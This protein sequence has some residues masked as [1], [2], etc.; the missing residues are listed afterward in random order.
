[1]TIGITSDTEAEKWRVFI[2]ENGWSPQ[3]LD[4]EPS[5]PRAFEVRAFPTYILMVSWFAEMTNTQVLVA[6][7]PFLF[8]KNVLWIITSFFQGFLKVRTALCNGG[9][10]FVICLLHRCTLCPSGF[11]LPPPR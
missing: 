4:R 3:Y 6:I 1:M 10:L 7:I 8:V 11:I 5:G 9:L 2:A